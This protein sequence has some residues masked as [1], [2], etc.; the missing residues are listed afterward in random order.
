M[1]TNFFCTSCQK[2]SLVDSNAFNHD[3]TQS[4]Q[5]VQFEEGIAAA[6]ESQ[7]IVKIAQCTIC[8]KT[9]TYFEKR[10]CFIIP[11]TK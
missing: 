1:I 8:K 11:Y 4:V 2:Q 6:G 5:G 10:I 3:K 7:S 9:F